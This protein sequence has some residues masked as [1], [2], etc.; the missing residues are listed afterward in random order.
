MKHRAPDESQNPLRRQWRRF[1]D[2]RPAVLGLAVLVL[3]G[4]MAMAAPVLGIWLGGDAISVD[5]LNRLASPSGDHPLGT[6]E[7]GRDVLVRLLHG[8]RASLGVGLATAAMAAVI[9]TTIGL[10][11]GSLGGR[12]DAALMRL[13]DGIIALPLLPLLIVLAAVDPTRMGLSPELLRTEGAGLVRIIVIV[14][15]VGWT[16]VARLVRGFVI[17][18]QPRL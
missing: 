8:G 15:L 2:H 13:T 9:G 4:A 7:L 3:F 5:L 16:T 17:S 6:D 11:A 12:V 1:T 14:A 18:L 10:V